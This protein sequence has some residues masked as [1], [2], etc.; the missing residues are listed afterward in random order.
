MLHATSRHAVYS[1]IRQSRKWVLYHAVEATEALLVADG[2]LL[3]GAQR[4]AAHDRGEARLQPYVTEA[5]TVRN[6]GCNRA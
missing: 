5:A 1:Y 2:F 4:R 3:F 6:R